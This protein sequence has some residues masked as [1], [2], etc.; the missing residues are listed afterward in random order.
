MEKRNF[1]LLAVILGLIVSMPFITVSSYGAE[2]TKKEGAIMV[3][4]GK[5]VKVIYTLKVDGKV[6]D[7]SNGR[8]PLEFKAGSRQLIPGFEK[9]VIGMKVGE[10]KSFKV[11]PE[12][13]YGPVDAKAMHD[14]PKNQL[15]PDIKPSAGMV[16]SAQSKDGRRIPVRIAEVKKDVVV[17]DFNHPLAGKTLNFDIE[18]VEIK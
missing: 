18:V 15:P 9:A 2:K 4:E 3:T 10:K 11:S 1:M 12:E 5:T 14:I 13:G 6:I 17:V 8:K 7:S 16:L